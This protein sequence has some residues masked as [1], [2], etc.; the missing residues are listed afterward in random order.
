MELVNLFSGDVFQTAS[1]AE[2]GVVRLALE[3]MALLLSPIVPHFAE[4]IW[5]HLGHSPSILE[6]P[7]P[8]YREDALRR[9][10][11]E[12]VIQ[13]NGKLRSRL[14]VAAG[15]GRAEI[16]AMALADE[17][18]CKFIGDKPV[19]KVIVVPGKLVNIVI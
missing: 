19:R 1:K 5:E 11:W 13:V 14:T 8:D 12:I 17:R 10:E 6:V 7:W 3:R 9:D 4:E 16:E 15:T 2:A 18:A